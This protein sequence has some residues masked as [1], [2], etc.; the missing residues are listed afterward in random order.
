MRV[1]GGTESGR[2][3]ALSDRTHFGSDGTLT[4]LRYDPNLEE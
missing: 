3:A 4:T 1:P 2:A